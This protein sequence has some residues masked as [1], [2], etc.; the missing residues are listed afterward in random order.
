MNARPWDIFNKNIGRVSAHAERVRMDV[1]KGCPKFTITGQCRACGCFMAAKTK[2]P[3]A[4][5]PI[6][7]WGIVNVPIKEQS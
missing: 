7:K 6:G 1:C 4:Y 2:L 5:C 3:N